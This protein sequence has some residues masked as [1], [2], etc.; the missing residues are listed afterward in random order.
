LLGNDFLNELPTTLKILILKGNKFTFPIQSLNGFSVLKNLT[1]LDLS[2]QNTNYFYSS[3]SDNSLEKSSGLVKH[4]RHLS[5]IIEN[6]RHLSSITEHTSSPP[7]PGQHNGLTFEGSHNFE[8]E[9]GPTIKGPNQNREMSQSN[10][11]LKISPNLRVLKAS[12]YPIFGMQILKRLSPNNNSLSVINF[13]N[14]FL[15]TWGTGR[16]P[17]GI[18]YAN[19]GYNY[20]TKINHNFF[21]GNNSHLHLLLNNNFLGSDFASDTKGA[22]FSKLLKA[23]HLDISTN[24][25][26]SIP[27]PFFSGLSSLKY[28]KMSDNKL[29]ML[30]TSLGT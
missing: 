14:S 28:L 26:Y 1:D 22:I 5:S 23:V 24:L 3:R 10:R 17:R 4:A 9:R 6:A 7:K 11:A 13:S 19:F 20:C 15:S 16:L 2:M 25:I 30:N 8:I 18:T 27:K 12:R 21:K 29:S